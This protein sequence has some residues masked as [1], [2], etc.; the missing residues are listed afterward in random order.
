LAHF[1]RAGD[2]RCGQNRFLFE[3]NNDS[4][5]RYFGLKKELKI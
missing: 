1:Q 4:S 3:V 5:S 2:G